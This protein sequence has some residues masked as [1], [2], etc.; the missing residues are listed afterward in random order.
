MTLRLLFETMGHEVRTAED[1]CTGLETARGFHPDAIFCDIGLPGGMD[2]YAVART[3][4]ADPLLKILFLSRSRALAKPRTSNWR[5]RRDS[6]CI[7]PSRA[8]PKR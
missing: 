5:E 7:L 1:G 6:I 8:T 4:R 3:M 2:G